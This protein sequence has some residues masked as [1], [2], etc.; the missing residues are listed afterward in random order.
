MYLEYKDTLSTLLEGSIELLN[1]ASVD[2][3][4]ESIWEQWQEIY[5]HDHFENAIDEGFGEGA[6]VYVA[7]LTAIL[8][9]FVLKYSDQ[10]GGANSAERTHPLCIETNDTIS[11]ANIPYVYDTLIQSIMK[12]LGA[13]RTTPRNTRKNSARPRIRVGGRRKHLSRRRRG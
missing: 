11:C 2:A 10:R 4:V 3:I 9:F 6:S 1:S 7:I 13:V 8:V 5:T 12:K